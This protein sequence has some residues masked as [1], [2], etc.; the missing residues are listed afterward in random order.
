VTLAARLS[1]DATFL[2][3]LV[4][5]AVVPRL[6]TLAQPLVE[7]HPF[8]QTWTAWTAKLFHERGIDLLHPLVPIFGPPFVLPSEFPLFQAVGA[9]VMWLGV[10]TDPAMRVS[11]LL[12]FAACAVALWLLARDVGGRAIAFVSVAI[13][14]T[15]PLAMLW[16]RTSMI[17]YLALGAGLA[18]CWAGLRWRDTRD[19]RWWAVA[20][21]FGIV[22]ALVK[23]P[24]YVGCA[25]PLALATVARDRAGLAAW[26][27]ARLDPLVVVLGLVPLAAAFGWLAYGDSVKVAEPATAFLR[28]NG[29]GWQ[30]YYYET[31][32]DRF[33]AAEVELVGGRLTGLV[34]GTFMLAFA[35][36]GIVAALRVPRASFWTGVVLAIVVP[37]E[38]FWGAYRRHDYYFVAVSAHAALL[39]ALGIVW[40][41]RRR[42][43]RT[44]RVAIATCAV[45]GVVAS[46]ASARAYWT[47]MYAGVS[48]PEQVLRGARLLA[49]AT[50]PDETVLILGF[51][52]DPSQPYYADRRALM[53]A[54][55]NF[56]T[57]I[58]TLD[59]ARYRTL[60]VH[61]PFVD[62]ISISRAWRWVGARESSIYRIG[63]TP[64]AVAD[65]FLLAT[66]DALPAASA[67]G[68]PIAV[69]CDFDG[70]VVPAG[71]RGTLLQLRS[72]YPAGA[73]VSVGF[74]SGPVPA[75]AAIWLDGARTPGATTVRVTCTG[76]E[77][78]FIERVSDAPRPG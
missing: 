68:G 39:V 64:A 29:P 46:L 13:F 28:S 72:G 52:Y 47:V 32:A 60:Y 58:P 63:D 66:D 18:F 71:Q 33:S 40:S 48:D 51:G 21:A 3:L 30:L 38:V 67:V 16:S 37:I 14:A 9:I 55:E 24:T 70:V 2:A 44:W 61:D 35:V 42:T 59:R 27:R 77:S 57:V 31:L 56:A 62:P 12:T 7:D 69:P 75:R 5:A 10:P 49:S 36:I 8:R 76:A 4:F 74:V 22:A 65:A 34:F 11:G 41:W 50:T 6:P 25:I 54:A 20:L 73:R 43:A 78:I 1:R 17:E 45:L 26:L 23:P 15:T 19:A 53:I